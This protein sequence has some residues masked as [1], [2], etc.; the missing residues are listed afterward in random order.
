M[1]KN[2]KIDLTG[3]KFGKWTVVEEA[4]NANNK[5]CSTRWL[6]R[7]ECG[8]MKEVYTGNLLRG[9][10]TSCGCGKHADLLGQRFGK[11][12]VVGYSHSERY[13]AQWRCICD[14]GNEVV[15]AA[16]S[17][18]SG[19]TKSCGCLTHRN[20]IKQ[21]CASE[22][23]HRIHRIW[24]GMKT[25]CYNPNATGYKNY[26][27]RGI[28]ICDEWKNDF[29]A[30]LD[31]AEQNGYQEHLTIDRIDNDKGYSPENCRWVTRAE[32]NRN[33]RTVKGGAVDA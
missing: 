13:V 32:Q 2:S 15:V 29:L 6:C 1:Q 31:W 10:S 20:G 17:L 23:A 9:K 11:L 8:R 27:G 12:T 25:R 14:C 28:I 7:C 18:R 19:H 24:T 4:K 3:K 5:A 33:K 30:F 22:P 16:E 21:L 26:G